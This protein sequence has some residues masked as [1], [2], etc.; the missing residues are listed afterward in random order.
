MK[1]DEM[2]ELYKIGFGGTN[3]LNHMTENDKN[4]FISFLH[5]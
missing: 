2:L 4:V 3:H 5:Q 1:S